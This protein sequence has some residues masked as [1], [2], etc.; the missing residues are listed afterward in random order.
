MAR[1]PQ[2]RTRKSRSSASSK[3]PYHHGNLRSELIA[4]ALKLLEEQGAAQL[5]LRSVARKLGVS[6]TAPYH[7]F[8]D[9]NALLAALATEGFRKLAA[10]VQNSAL[11]EH[12][13]EQRIS[14]LCGGLVR[15]ARDNPELFRT[16]YDGYV[17]NKM[18]YP[19]LVEAASNS[20]RTLVRR[21]GDTLEEFG[22]SNID[23]DYAAMSIFCL[24]Y[25]MASFIVEKRISPEVVNVIGDGRA[26]VRQ[27][28]GILAAGFN[29]SKKK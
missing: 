28:S 27:V 12:P 4:A 11:Q 21:V 13:F 20:Y 23:V 14:R 1:S 15:F 19:E 5:S 16:M 24:G 6:Q 9:K 7:H 26:F 10:N 3:A 8:A 22:V 2:K 17:R 18:E 25:G 29:N